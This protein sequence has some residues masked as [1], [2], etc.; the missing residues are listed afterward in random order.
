[1]VQYKINQS[2]SFNHQQR[3]LLIILP[4]INYYLTILYLHNI[5]FIWGDQWGSDFLLLPHQCGKDQK[6]RPSG[7][8][9]SVPGKPGAGWVIL[10]LFLFFFSPLGHNSLHR[11][12]GSCNCLAPVASLGA[13]AVT[14]NYILPL[15]PLKQFTLFCE[16]CAPRMGPVVPQRWIKRV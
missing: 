14:H 7:L 6:L 1:M 8:T 15:N 10:F 2:V 3:P 13:K 12:V 11:K 5:Y 4:Y 9:V 16:T